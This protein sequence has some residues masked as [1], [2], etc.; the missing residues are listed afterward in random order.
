MGSIYKAIFLCYSTY[1]WRLHDI[2]Y[3][4]I[5]SGKVM[6][7]KTAPAL[8]CRVYLTKWATSLENPSQMLG[9]AG[10][11]WSGHS[12]FTY[13]NNICKLYFFSRN[14][15]CPIPTALKRSLNRA[16]AVCICNKADYIV[17]PLTKRLFKCIV[18][19]KFDILVVSHFLRKLYGFICGKSQH[20]LNYI[21]LI[22]WSWNTVCQS[23]LCVKDFAS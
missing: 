20:D 22:R 5:I 14:C 1:I 21:C 19:L 12:I 15:A 17:Q 2:K 13:L 11:T 8:I 23:C 3:N 18:F 16:F 6:I 4:L 9:S 7:V 10:K